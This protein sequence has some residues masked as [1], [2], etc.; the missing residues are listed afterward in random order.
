MNLFTVSDFA[1]A[2]QIAKQETFRD[3]QNIISPQFTVIV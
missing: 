2:Q 1:K 3:V